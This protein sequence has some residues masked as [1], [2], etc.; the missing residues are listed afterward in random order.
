MELYRK[1][2]VNPLGGCFPILIQMPIF[3]A[4]YWALMESVELRQAPFVLWIKDLS[5]YDPYFIL[6]IIYGVS[7]LLIQKM[8]PTPVTDPMQKKIMM[9]MPVVFTLMFCTFPAGLTLYWCVS[10]IFTIVQ[11]KVIYSQLEKMGLQQ[12]TPKKPKQ[13]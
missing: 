1:E 6:P 8:T 12:R 2:H 13:K 7:L 10:N 11:Q 5:I 4:L 3:I 9:A